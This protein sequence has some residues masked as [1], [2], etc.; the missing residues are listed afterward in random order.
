MRRHGLTA[1][2]AL[3]LGACH[4]APPADPTATK[5][6][7]APPP[8]AAAE[9]A[10]EKAPEGVEAAMDV[11]RRYYAAIAAGDHATAYRLWADDGRAS[12]QDFARFSRGFSETRAVQATLG[13]PGGIEG[14]AGSLY[15]TIP[16][17]VSAVLNDG[18]RQHFTGAYVLRRVNDV[19][20][21]TAAQRRWHIQSA[22][23]R[24]D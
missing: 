12:G 2:L 11:V 22:S 9:P 21:A 17:T 15:V 4:A 16:V 14:A 19:P 7:A 24:R 13:A 23:M 8:A 5:D 20:G 1:T 10:A 6:G 18:T 3:I